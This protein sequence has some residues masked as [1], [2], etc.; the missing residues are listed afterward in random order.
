MMR[1][2]LSVVFIVIFLSACSENDTLSPI[3]KADLDLEPLETSAAKKSEPLDQDPEDIEEYVEFT[4]DEEIISLSIRDIPILHQFLQVQK[5]PQQAI[6][7]MELKKYVLGMEEFFILC[8]SCY[9]KQC[10]YLLLHPDQN[11]SAFLVAD[12][13]SYVNHTF[14]PDAT[15]VAFHFNRP[16]EAHLVPSHVIVFD[17][18]EWTAVTM[19][20]EGDEAFGLGF[21]WPIFSIEWSDDSSLAIDFPDLNEPTEEA[22][23]A[24]TTLEEPP[25]ITETYHLNLQ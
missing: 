8:F 6:S 11:K 12:M 7:D 1:M 2:V 19:R 14:S 4:I 10:S 20:N 13:A 5:K 3:H 9:D 18:K 22:L 23:D 25:F 17:L 16:G 24:W 15:K 21:T